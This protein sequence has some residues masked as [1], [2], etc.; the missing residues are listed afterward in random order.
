M[1]QTEA[2]TPREREL[3]KELT[4]LRTVE[5]ISHDLLLSVNTVKTHLRGI[6]RKLNATSRRQAVA[7]AERAGLL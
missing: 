4:T 6:Y 5:E 7:A 1:V 2:L 3:L